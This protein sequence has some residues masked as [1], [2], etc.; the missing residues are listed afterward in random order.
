MLSTGVERVRGRKRA[1]VVRRGSM[2]EMAFHLGLDGTAELRPRHPIKVR[3]D[4]PSGK[5]DISPGI[6]ALENNEKTNF[7]HTKASHREAGQMVGI[8]EQRQ[9]GQDRGIF[10]IRLRNCTLFYRQ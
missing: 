9:W 10:I 5:T 6:W 2:E 8:L 4:V 1:G 7:S 3:E